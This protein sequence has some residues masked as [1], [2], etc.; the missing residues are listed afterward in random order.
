MVRKLHAL[1][2]VHLLHTSTL[3]S[4]HVYCADRVSLRYGEWISD[5]AETL[6]SPG[7]KFELGFFGPTGSSGDK[8]YVGI[9]YTSDKQIVVWVANRN[10]P[11]INTIAG[12]FGFTTDGNLTALDMSSGKVHWSFELDSYYLCDPCNTTDRIVNLTDFGHLV[13]FNNE[14]SLWESFN[15]PTG[16]FLPNMTMNR[17]MN[18]TSWRDRDDPGTGNLT[19]WRA[20]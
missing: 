12:A 3:C 4:F 6:V 15:N 7:R 2:H 14:T 20:S 10:S 5:H 9:W 19:S 1:F 18:L 17:Y 8:R 13:L 16:T 11:L